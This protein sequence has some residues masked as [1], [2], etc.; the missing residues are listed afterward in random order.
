M[1]TSIA[2]KYFPNIY[3]G[4]FYHNV[5]R[6]ILFPDKLYQGHKTNFCG[7]AA[8]TIVMLKNDPEIYTGLILT[9]YKEGKASFRKL[10]L[11]PSEPIQKVA[12]ALDGKGELNLNPADQLWFLTLAD[13]YKDYLNLFNHTYD[14]GD[15]N[16]N[17][18][19]VNLSKFR[20]MA[21]E[22]TGI[23]TEA[24]GS[25]LIRPWV[26]DYL[27]YLTLELNKGTVVLFVNSK[28]LYPSKYRI[29]NL[30]APTHFIVLYEINLIDGFYELKYWDYGM[31]TVQLFTEKRMHQLIYGVI[32]FNNRN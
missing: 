19:S 8:L 14:P 16:N 27:E 26:N 11:E 21:H 30:H 9:M 29:F 15:E 3:P 32:R 18:A 20:R 25:D 6:N 28:Y 31:K 4:E 13:H 5:E 1:D 24:I 2:S 7:Y 12:G 17:W 22:L 23:K 10:T